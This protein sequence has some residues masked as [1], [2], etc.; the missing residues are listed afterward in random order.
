[1]GQLAKA[2]GGRRRR[3]R[4]RCSALRRRSTMAATRTTPGC[5]KL[6]SRS[7]SSPGTMRPCS[8]PRPHAASASRPAT[9]R[10]SSS[11]T[12][13]S[14]CR[15]WS[16]RGAPSSR[17]RWRSATG[18]RAAGRVGNGVGVNAYKLRTSA[19]P[20]FD[21]GARLEPTGGTHRLVT[22]ARA[23]EPRRP[24]DRPGGV[25]RGVSQEPEGRTGARG[26]AAPPE[27]A[28]GG[29]QVR[30]RARSG[31]WRSTSTP[32]SAATPA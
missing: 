2:S 6:P 16:C 30:R 19:A 13:S 20:G 22:H 5:R 11:A 12:A 24:R 3:P 18:E 8:R 21:V 26:R 31:A 10:D 23:L 1:M 7:A 32:A 27:V 14:P 29:A 28:L 17:S 25:A 15:C 9:S 4:G